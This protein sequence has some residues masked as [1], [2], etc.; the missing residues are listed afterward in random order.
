MHAG[1][2][3]ALLV[4]GEAGLGKSAL[5]RYAADRPEQTVLRCTGVESEVELQLAGLLELCRPVLDRLDELAEPQAT[6]LQGAVGLG[7]A[8]PVDRFML[9]ASLLS[10]LAAVADETSLLVLVD[11]AQWLDRASTDALLFAARRMEADRVA[12]VLAARPGFQLPGVGVLRLSGLDVDA[13][14]RLLET[15]AGGSVEPRVAGALHAATLGNPLGLQE[16]ASRLTS[17]QLAGVE[18]LPDPLP[19][20]ASIEQAFAHRLKPLSAPAREVLLLAALSASGRL[21]V[22]AAALAQTV[23]SVALLE[24]AEDAGLVLIDGERVAFTHP[25]ARS[26]VV[27][28]ATPS[29]RRAAHR[30]LA[31]AT[32]DGGEDE[33]AWHL[34]AAALAPDEEVAALLEGA[35]ERASEHSGHATAAAAFER[36][37]QLTPDRAVRGRRLHAAARAAWTAGATSRA[38]ELLDEAMRQPADPAASARML[39]LR[40]QI[41]RLA[42]DVSA[43]IGMLD[44]AAALAA[45]VDAH[46]AVEMLCDAIEACMFGDAPGR[47]LVAGTRLRT[48]APADGGRADFLA[49]QGYGTALFLNGRAADAEVQLAR[50]L[51]ILAARGDL[52][53]EPRLLTLGAIAA[54]WLD[55]LEEGLRLATHAMQAARAQGAFTVLA[56][57]LEVAT[58]LTMRRGRWQEAYAHGTQAV[59]LGRET[60]ET[61]VTAYCLSHLALMEAARGQDERC[62]AHAEEAL[63]LAAA[64]GIISQWPKR[65]LA[66][67][68]VGRGRF[69]EALRHLAGADGAIVER[70]YYERGAHLV[71][72][73][74]RLG[75][76][77][78]AQEAFGRYFTLDASTAFADASA[79]AARCRGL[80]ADEESFEPHLREAAALQDAIGDSFGLARTRL[81]LGERLR[82]VGRKRDARTELTAALDAFEA[83][84]AT[85]WSA[86][87]RAEL[88][89]SGATL[90][91]RRPDEG[92]ELTPQEL[93]VAQHVAAGLTNKEVALA[94]F[95]SPKTVDY[96][97]GRI[98]RKLDVRSRTVLARR[99]VGA[100]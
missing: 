7:G 27:Q 57:A 9:G 2:A 69:D 47:A 95:L 70:G 82:R 39:Q 65:A 85:R 35:G 67:L 23:S 92:E 87:A 60:G 40:G 90:R 86:R 99:F 89:A 77:E 43:A 49:A 74:V 41:E 12:F 11:D 64:R 38:R 29:Q 31:R 53:A 81:W 68:D 8:G 14:A 10:L 66:L 97:L 42:G 1:R 98:Y 48:L 28:T 93:Q 52:R 37:A 16:I 13:A 62:R 73:H 15:A 20:G 54:S 4:L 44:R 51:D 32:V 45:D 88:S 21:D 83:M 46:S 50:A 80:L 25:L 72:A 59:T 56:H 84:G 55:R 63:A 33:R 61:T 76:V 24:E 17:T 75:R 19:V 79:L 30:A 5:L 100:R 26:I 6:A 34:A 94:L 78:A 91:R 18:R 36:A 22:V 3:G 96:H 71:E 58:W